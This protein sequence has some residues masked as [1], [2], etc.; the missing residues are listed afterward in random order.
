MSLD[1][2]VAAV[3]ERPRDW[4]QRLVSSLHRRAALYI[5]LLLVF[6]LGLGYF[7]TKIGIDNSLKVWFVEGDPALTAYDDYKATFGN[8]ETIVIAATAPEGIYD[9]AY[10]TRVRAAS[11]AIE[12]LPSVR[13]VQSLAVSLHATDEDGE[14][15]VG[16]LL[17]ETG[18]VDAA[19]AAAVRRRVAADPQFQGMLVG[20]TDHVSLILVE[21]RNTADYEKHRKDVIHDVTVVVNRELKKDGGG[22][23]LGGIGV[24]YEG[25]NEASLHDTGIFVTLSYLILLL[26]LWVSFRRVVWVLI[27][28]AIVTVAVLATMGIAG[29][30]G[31]D[32]N[33]VTGIVPTLIMTVGILDLVH[34]VDSFEE[35]AQAGLKPADILRT[36]VALTVVPCIINSVTDV[37]G[38]AS[39]IRAP[40]GAIRDLGWLVSVG[41]TILLA[42]VLIIGI[43]AM[44]RFGGRSKR[45]TEAATKPADHGIIGRIVLGMLHVA[46]RYRGAVFAVAGVLFAVS[47]WGMT[48]LN[49]DT[50]TIGFLPEDHPVR[51]DDAAIA[52]DFGPYIPLEFTVEPRDGASVYEP[53]ALAA[54]DRVERAFE[55][56]PDIGRVTGLPEIV[57]QVFRVYSGDPAD[58][59][60]PDKRE[61]VAQLLDTVY[62]QSKDGEDNLNA[63]LDVRDEPRRTHITARSGLPSA[64]TIAGILHDLDRRADA[65]T[66]HV[67]VR[68]SGYLPLYVRITQNITTAQ[69]QSGITAFVLVTLVMSLMLR[70]LK[71]GLLSMV[72]NLLPAMMTL[73]LMGF[74]GIPLDLATVLIAAI[75]IG[76]SVNDT[77]HIMFRFRHEHR[78]TPDDPDAA[79]HRMM[80]GTGRPVVMSSLILIA[81]FAVLLGASVKSVYYFGLLTTI[82]TLSALISDLLVTPALILLVNKK[83]RATTPA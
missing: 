66:A 7:A 73:G 30:A 10:L 83:A 43:P 60:I 57:K 58:Y 50:Y 37:I 35:G 23:H 36:T 39:F 75:V 24:V 17:P 51:V 78:R 53:E 49:V 2:E 25:L 38:F 74:V 72:P 31:R 47:A 12:A 29:L 79:M 68:P 70:S 81:G 61:G 82:T 33:M 34:L 62:A 44:A 4:A 32:M 55:D 19:A 65:E 6:A 46:T 76:I 52:Q 48:K 67:D 15:V 14:L 59:R 21:P 5:S 11:Q 26:G 54:I 80:L 56:H 9:P 1:K 77:S 27:G 69:L 28:A 18:E 41:L 71:L 63:L 8:D 20:K 45:A 64:N 16:P 3:E 40:V 22:A 13:R 42:S